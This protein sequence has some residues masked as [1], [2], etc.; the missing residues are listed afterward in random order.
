MKINIFGDI[1]LHQLKYGEFQFPITLLSILENADFNIGNLENPI[2]CSIEK[3]KNH[4]IHLKSS[5]QSLSLLKCFDVFSLANNHIL[6]Y[7]D[8]GLFN[9]ISA[10]KN[11]GFQYFGVGKNLAKAIKPVILD[12]HIALIGATRY[13]NARLNKFGTGKDSLLLLLPLILELKKKGYFIIIYFHWGYEYIRYPSP[14]DRILARICIDAGADVIVGAHPHIFQGVEIYKGKL[15]CYSLGNFIFHSSVYNKYSFYK[16][17]SRLN[18][19]YFISLSIDEG[20]KYTYNLHGYHT[21]D[22]GIDLYDSKRNKELIK[23]I[24]EISDLFKKSYIKYLQKYFDQ[25][26]II[27]KQNI[28]IRKN[29]QDISHKSVLEKVE[30]YSQANLQDLCN[31]ILNIFI[32]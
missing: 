20:C 31:R 12:N 5:I 7:N 23:K 6:D 18:E 11:N 21:D 32:K 27:S 25:V 19:S 15:I 3:R 9:T 29:Y 16:N 17:D 30:V 14:R 8:Q 1:S 28:K 2:T 26:S 10:L 24:Q 13:A 22:F 4:P